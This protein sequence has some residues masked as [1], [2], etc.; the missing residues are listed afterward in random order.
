[1]NG[2]VYTRIDISPV[3]PLL[4]AGD[5]DGLRVLEF[6]MGYQTSMSG[7]DNRSSS[8][9]AKS[10]NSGVRIGVPQVTVPSSICQI[11][12]RRNCQIFDRR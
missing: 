12:N 2:L 3:G 8:R 1:V 4:L 11:F 9:Q 6:R 7:F 10:R 5:D